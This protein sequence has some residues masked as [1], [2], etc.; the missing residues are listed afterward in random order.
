M[1]MQKKNGPKDNPKTIRE[2]RND[3]ASGLSTQSLKIANSANRMKQMY[4]QELR[5][6][7]KGKEKRTEQTAGQTSEQAIEQVQDSGRWAAGELTSTVGHMVRQG[8]DYAKKKAE[9]AKRDTP[10]P[11]ADDPAEPQPYISPEGAPLKDSEQRPYVHQSTAPEAASPAA[12]GIPEQAP[13]AASPKGPKTKNRSMAAN[14]PKERRLVL[15]IDGCK[16]SVKYSDQEN[17][18]A[19]QNI[20]DTLISS[21][22]IKR[23]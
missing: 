23:P 14:A 4:I 8:R 1:G 2:K 21:G 15:Y 10:I 22:S 13:P 16:V 7:S 18:A 6:G 12:E 19:V 5:D 3:D 9:T 17:P 20:K 11:P